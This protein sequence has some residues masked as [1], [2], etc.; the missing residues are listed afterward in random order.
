MKYERELGEATWLDALRTALWV[1]EYTMG[2]LDAPKVAERA[3]AR[4]RGVEE[5]KMVRRA[6]AWFASHVLRHVCEAGRR[7]V[8]EHKAAGD[9]V[10]IVTGATPYV[11]IPLAEELGIEHV[12][13]SELEVEGGRLTGKPCYPLCYGEG[14]VARAE[15]LAREQGFDLHQSTFYTDSLSDLPLLEQV[16][17]PVLVNPDWRLRRV[18][19]R[20]GWRVER[21]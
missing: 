15:R 12:V 20:R 17:H 10:A 6:R 21:W 4:Y 14:K 3:L 11:A 18:G 13:A 8:H 16:A 5:E 2:V 7:A 9:L 1:L 19:A